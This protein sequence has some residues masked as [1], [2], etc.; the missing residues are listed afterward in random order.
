MDKIILKDLVARGII[1]LNDW[2]REK[3][4]E[5][6]INIIAYTDIRKTAESDDI[7][8]SVNYR[9]LA[10]KAQA[11]AETAKRLTV[12]ALASDIAAI[13]LEDPNVKKIL[14]RVEKPGAVRFAKSVGV[15]IE[16]SREE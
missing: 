16:R 9:T 14:V 3:P 5:I 6:L 13:G 7:D 10:K 4:Q 2:E 11:H 8:F 15:E 12:E 1:G